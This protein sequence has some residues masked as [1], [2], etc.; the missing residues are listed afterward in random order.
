MRLRAYRRTRTPRHHDVPL[1]S[2]R[3]LSLDSAHSL[4]VVGCGRA[5]R[6]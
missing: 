3:S 2:L 4:E 6:E 5:I 1:D